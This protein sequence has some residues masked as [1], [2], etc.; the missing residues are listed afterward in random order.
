LDNYETSN[1]R[2]ELRF[3]FA[4]VCWKHLDL[5]GEHTGSRGEALLEQSGESAVQLEFL[6]ETNEKILDRFG[7]PV[8]GTA[9]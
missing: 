7:F 3:K 9:N 6:V 2:G 8:P 4:K 1:S 5:P